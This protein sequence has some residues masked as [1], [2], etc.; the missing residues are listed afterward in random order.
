VVSRGGRPDLAAAALDD[1]TA[2][3][4]L[5]VGGLDYGVIELNEQA[6]ARLKAPKAL[7]IVPG[8]THLFPELGALDIVIEHAARWFK[9][10]LGARVHPYAG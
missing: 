3:T 2:P 8:A 4:L 7:E 9:T 1:V 10:H 6:F 5:I